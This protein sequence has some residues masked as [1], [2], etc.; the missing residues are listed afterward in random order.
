MKHK[1]A[2]KVLLTAVL[3]L[4]LFI[5][6]GRNQEVSAS[7]SPATPSNEGHSQ[8]S[9]PLKLKVVLERVYLD[10]E[11]S[12]ESYE[13]N[14]T[15]LADFWAKYDQWELAEV[16]DSK[17]V[18]RKKMDDIS[19]L[20][21]SNGYFGITDKGVLSIFNGRPGQSRIIQSFFQIDVE[22]LES[23]K[24][25]EL[26]QGIPIRTKDRYMKVLE[27]FKPYSTDGMQCQ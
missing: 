27:T 26:F 22:K 23:H 2:A 7:V 14:V 19:P 1:N 9:A 8:P 5:A 10:G 24:Q 4:F 6:M 16:C 17:L 11:M 20:L 25:E 13:E 15:S 18:F 3:L 12:E 21:K